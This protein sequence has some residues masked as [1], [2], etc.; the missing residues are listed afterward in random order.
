MVCCD[1]I[2][3]C[4]DQSEFEPAHPSASSDSA[5]DMHKIR[6][7]LAGPPLYLPDEGKH[8]VRSQINPTCGG[9]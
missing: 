8:A 2:F 9:W 5:S 1:I 3:C 7:Y 6:A 4:I